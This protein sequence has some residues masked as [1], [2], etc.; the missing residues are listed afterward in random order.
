MKL[1]PPAIV[2]QFD[3]A[4]QLQAGNY[5]GEV[6]GGKNGDDTTLLTAHTFGNVIADDDAYDAGD[7]AAMAA[8]ADARKGTEAM[9]TA[10][11]NGTETL[12][13]LA[14]S[15]GDSSL[16]ITSLTMPVDD[17]TFTSG[18][19]KGAG[20]ATDGTET[21]PDLAPSVGGLSLNVASLTM[22]VED[23]TVTSEYIKGAGIESVTTGNSTK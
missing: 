14:P 13:D 8:D 1:L 6:V 19:T 17:T 4:K 11:T 22:S 5:V 18:Y 9:N 7:A 16:N 23:T 15:V 21:L 2:K 20:V 10:A 3:Q 12:L